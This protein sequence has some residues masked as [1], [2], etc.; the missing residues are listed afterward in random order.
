M[1]VRVARF[2]GGDP[3]GIDAELARLREQLAAAKRG[4]TG[5][6]PP[7]LAG[8]R[9]VLALVDRSTGN[10]LDLTFCGTADDLRAADEALN[11]MS[12]LSD[13]SGHRVSVEMYEVGV[14]ETLG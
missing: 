6:M 5:D 3:S 12:P 2:E 9:R 13:A 11:A 7:G 10:S 8:I 14:D 1:F 4:E